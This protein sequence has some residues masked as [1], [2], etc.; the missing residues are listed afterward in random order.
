[1]TWARASNSTGAFFVCEVA[2]L[3][4]HHINPVFKITVARQQCDGRSERLTMPHARK[5]FD[6]V[7]FD[8]HAPTA[9]V[10][11]LPPPKLVIDKLKVNR[12]ACGQAFDDG[13]QP[14]AVRFSRGCESKVAHRYSRFT[15]Q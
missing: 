12:Q 2:R 9:P 15:S 3:D 5:N 1:M 10:T 4:V 14:F 13:D 7:L 8:L 11:L 6:F